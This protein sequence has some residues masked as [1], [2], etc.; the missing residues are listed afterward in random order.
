MPMQD[1][2]LPRRVDK[3]W[4]HELWF[5]LTEHYAGKLLHVR[6]EQRLSVQYHEEKD[7][8]SYLL[9]GRLLLHRGSDADK[10][11]ATELTAGAAWRN[12][13]RQIHTIEALE[14]AVVVEVSTP[15]LD[16][17]VRLTDDYGRAGTSAP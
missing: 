14:D 9:S 15:E 8:S 1:E 3:P 11:T 13:P 16:D 12:E 17:V 2:E 10:L 5:A 4:G 6:A 7:E